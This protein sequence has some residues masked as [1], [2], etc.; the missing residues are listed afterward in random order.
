METFL[1]SIIISLEKI[2]EGI[3]IGGAGGSIAGL[4]IW[5]LQLGRDKWTERKH[6]DKV[7]S[8]LYKRTGKHKGLTVGFPNDP[9]WKS[10]IEIASYTN[11]T[12]ERVRYICSVHNKIRP[13][14]EKDLWSGESWEEKWGIKEFIDHGF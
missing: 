12:P 10:T 1:V 5:L 9:R 11:L 13:K 3:V 14:I 4:A 8:W 7:Y 6:R 2:V